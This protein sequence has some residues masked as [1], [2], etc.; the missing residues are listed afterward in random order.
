M[1]IHVPCP[2]CGGQFLVPDDAIG[3]RRKC[4]L[5]LKAVVVSR[6]PWALTVSPHATE[7]ADVGKDDTAVSRAGSSPGGS[8][9][10]PDSASCQG[11]GVG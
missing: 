1:S 11:F 10:R 7:S 4:P 5:C 8:L 3:K 9:F 2:A 6:D